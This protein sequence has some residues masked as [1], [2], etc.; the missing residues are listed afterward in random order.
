MPPDLVMLLAF[1]IETVDWLDKNESRMLNQI[2]I[3]VHSTSQH[4]TS[5]SDG[6]VVKRLWSGCEEVPTSFR[7]DR[8]VGLCW[9]VG[10][11]FE[12]ESSVEMNLI[13]LSSTQLVSRVICARTLFAIFTGFL[14]YTYLA[15]LSLW[16]KH[17]R[18][19]SEY[20]AEYYHCDILL[21]WSCSGDWKSGVLFVICEE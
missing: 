7:S 17:I 13:S 16:G 8:H 6:K 18:H 2:Q 14:Q 12:S 4:T 1:L 15:F 20:W 11:W 21:G 5:W 10:R 9:L 3:I 19:S